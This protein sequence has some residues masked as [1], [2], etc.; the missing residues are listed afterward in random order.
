MS[1]KKVLFESVLGKLFLKTEDFCVK[2]SYILSP[3]SK[4]LQ[5]RVVHKIIFI[6]SYT[7]IKQWKNVTPLSLSRRTNVIQNWLIRYQWSYDSVCFGSWGA[8]LWGSFG[9]DQ[10]GFRVKENVK[11]TEVSLYL[12]SVVFCVLQL[13][14][15]LL[16]F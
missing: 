2:K 12:L 3:S 9:R 11:D 4:Y 14:N 15:V 10:F 1:K 16:C 6:F 7:V 13:L 5:T 8:R